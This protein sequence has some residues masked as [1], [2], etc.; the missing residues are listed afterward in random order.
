M[1]VPLHW[2][3]NGRE[4]ISNR[5]PHD[6][7]LNRLFRRR[8]KK[9]SKLRVTG[10]CVGNSPGTGEFPAHMASN[11]ENVS[12][13]WRHHDPFTCRPQVPN[14]YLNKGR[15]KIDTVDNAP[16]NN[17][18]RNV[19]FIPKDP[20]LCGWNRSIEQYDNTEISCIQSR[21]PQIHVVRDMYPIQ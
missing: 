14:H 10:L 9:T 4:S 20:E 5:Q 16:K 8:S 6:C 11:A 17:F 3:H 13:W 12:I 21:I 19:I 1:T 18:K 7:L 15:F 2:R